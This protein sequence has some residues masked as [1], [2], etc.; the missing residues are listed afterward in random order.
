MNEKMLTDI[1]YMPM[2]PP[3]GN[4]KNRATIYGVYVDE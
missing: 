4:V 3:S 1:D 2:F